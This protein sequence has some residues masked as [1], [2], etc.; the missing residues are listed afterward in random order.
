MEKKSFIIVGQ[1][2]AG[3][4]L[5][6]TLLEK[7]CSVIVADEP[8]IS[9]ASRIAAGLYNPVVFKRLV[10]SWMADELIPFM[11]RFYTKTEEK[12]NTRF[13]YKKNIVK[14]FTEDQEKELWKKKSGEEVGKYLGKEIRSEFLPNLIHSPEGT[15]EV[16]NAGNLDTL[17][18]LTCFRTYFKEQGILIEEK[19]DHADLLIEEG[20]VKFNGHIA[21][22][23]IFCEGYKAL[24]NP[25]FSWLPFKLT[26]GEILTIK[27]S[28]EH[29]IPLEKVIN[30]GVFILPLGKGLYKVGATS[31]WNDLNETPTEK[32]K[33]ELSDK[34]DK[35]LRVPYEIL[36]H[37]A[38]IRPTV[39]DRRPLIGI[40]PQH[41]QLAVFNGM[42]TKAVMLSPYFADQFANHLLHGS[43]IDKEADIAR[44]K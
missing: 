8:S 43:P 15:A 1:G 36:E 32:G 6:A 10:K 28:G 12:L 24:E 11:D 30:K 22:K 25:W 18:Y 31:E 41:P 9:A 34:L 26:K 23:I 39:N 29:Q 27:L 37:K 4:T 38:G 5:A 35:V 42:G 40:H 2:I 3:T 13:Y 21:D 17:T 20:N 14:L 33:K 19:F 16:L 44:F 7:G